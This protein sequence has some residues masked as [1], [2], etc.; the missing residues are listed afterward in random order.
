MNDNDLNPCP[1]CGGKALLWP[2][3]PGGWQVGC[4][5]DD[6]EVQCWVS[7][8][9]DEAAVAAVWNQR[10]ALAPSQGYVIVQRAPLVEMLEQ[11][12]DALDD[13]GNADFIDPEDLAPAWAAMLEW[14]VK[15]PG[16]EP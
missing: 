10:A 6:C 2:S 3:Y 16:A 5:N 7:S 1:F 8:R 9:K 4:A 14:C 12:W 15:H 11:G 13:E